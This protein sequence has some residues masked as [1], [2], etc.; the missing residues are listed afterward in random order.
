MALTVNPTLPVIAATPAAA[1][2]LLAL[3]PG[4]VVNAQ[5]LNTLAENLVQIAIAGLTIDVLSEVPL[6]AGQNLQLAVSQTESGIRLAIVPSGSQSASGA[7]LDA[8]TLT[9]NAPLATPATASAGPTSQLNQLTPL[10][11][12]VV[13]AAA[14]TAATQQGSQAPLFANL[15]SLAASNS[16]PP[17]LQQAVLQVLAQRTPLD[18]TLDGSDIQSGFQKSGLLLEAQLASGSPSPASGIPDLKAAL[19]VLRQTL[20]TS[21]GA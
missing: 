21:L 13:A 6:Q 3:Q 8:V 11:R 5:V 18:P 17:P 10:E 15:S 20:V 7:Y 16:L 12:A 2:P 4:A 19:I 9:P 1:T 14:E